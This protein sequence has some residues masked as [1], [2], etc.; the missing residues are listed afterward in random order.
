MTD[1]KSWFSGENYYDLT[2]FF[3]QNSSNNGGTGGDNGS[4]SRR[5]DSSSSS[6]DDAMVMMLKQQSDLDPVKQVTRIRLTF[7]TCLQAPGI[8]KNRL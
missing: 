5:N 2:P 3:F 8:I 1:L 6:F 4:S 7:F